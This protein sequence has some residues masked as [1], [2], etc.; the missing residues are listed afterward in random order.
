VSLEEATGLTR[1]FRE[2]PKASL[3]RQAARRITMSLSPNDRLQHSLHPWSSYVIVPLF[4]LA[5]AGLDLRGGLL[6]E[7]FGTPLV[8]SIVIALVVGKSVGISVGAWLA[9]RPW[10]GG[11]PL[12]VGWPS[13][14]AASSVAGIGFTMSLLIA[15][16]SYSEPVLD[17][18]KLGI[19]SASVVAAGIGTVLFRALSA[20]PADWLRR[21]EAAVAPPVPDLTVSV[22]ALR[23]HVRGAVRAPIT[24]VEY[25][26]FECPWCKRAAPHIRSILEEL[27]G[28]VRFVFRHL[29]LTDV[30]PNA[31]LAAEAAEA[32]GAQ[33]AF[34]E[35]HDLLFEH[36][37]A[38]SLPDLVRYAGELGLDV[39]RFEADL[40]SG[41]FAARV[42]WDVNSAE[43]SG[44]AGTP[45]Y[46][47]NDVRYRGSL[48]PA[49][50]S[51]VLSGAARA[52]SMRPAAA[53]AAGAGPPTGDT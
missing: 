25:G 32:A 41:R 12:S 2:A 34:W 43:E 48:D 16:L 4:A 23:D 37:D 44:V 29:P 5:N 51:A 50:V 49:A 28:R 45:T 8:I 33:G 31:A 22:D 36:Q 17:H 52:P 30:H 46:F 14:I 21:S 35:M 10:L 53:A 27:D 38:L 15:E 24:V 6:G 11:A 26:D 47:I 18:A 1:A 9:T 39:T 42:T 3:A 20:I 7:A 13:L 19:L 40:R